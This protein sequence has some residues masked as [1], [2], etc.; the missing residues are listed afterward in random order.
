[1]AYLL[2]AGMP[3]RT[4]TKWLGELRGLV[5]LGIAPIVALQARTNGSN[6]IRYAPPVAPKPPI[7]AA[8][9]P[10][11]PIPVET[12]ISVPKPV[13]LPPPPIVSKPPVIT[14][15]IVSKPPVILP[16]PAPVVL[17]S[18]PVTLPIVSKP[19]VILPQPPPVT[20]PS[21]SVASSPV[22]SN[23][24]KSGA[25]TDGNGNIWTWDGKQW[26]ISGSVATGGAIT[27]ASPSSPVNV[28]VS[29]AN[30]SGYQTILDWLTQQTLISGVPNW[31]IGGAAV[32]LGYKVLGKG[33]R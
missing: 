20:A 4:Q 31:V 18:P 5:G 25:Y 26:A 19:P 21:S 24:P 16:P 3:P 27:S 30:D 12:P 17:P 10:V 15:P 22:P 14:L 2:P 7:V 1:M 29:P 33:G 28:T 8:P 13:V 9:K 32:L 6:M 23:F 11:Y